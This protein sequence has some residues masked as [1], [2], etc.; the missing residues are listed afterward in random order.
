M[1][2]IDTNALVRFMSEHK[3][4]TDEEFYNRYEAYFNRPDI[5]GWEARNA[6]NDLAHE[7]AIAEPKVYEIM[8][9]V[10]FMIF[11]NNLMCIFELGNYCCIE[12]CPP[13][14]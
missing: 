11:I 8:I 10:I 12:S 2:V 5:D 14:E 7:D 4:E 9:M 3:A 6:M 1:S 13:F